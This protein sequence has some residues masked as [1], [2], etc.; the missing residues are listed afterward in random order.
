MILDHHGVQ[1]NPARDKRVKLPRGERRHVI[2]PAGEHVLAILE[3]LPSRYRLPL[4]VLDATGMRVG[5]LE[6]LTWATATRTVPAG[7]SRRRWRKRGPRGGFTRRPSCSRPSWRS[8]RATTALPSGRCSSDS[9]PTASARRSLA[10]APRPGCHVLAA[11]PPNRRVSLLH[12]QGLSWAR[13][14]ERVG[15]ADLVTT[16]RTYT[17]VLG[18]EKELE[19]A[20]LLR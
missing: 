5:E 11:R 20:M 3:L 18:D 10:P 2:P 15:H 8:C 4:L 17:H 12:A 13:I 9:A 16:A 6:A 14:G 7:A 19:Y 1:P